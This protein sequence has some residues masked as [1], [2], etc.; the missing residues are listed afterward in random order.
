M[1]FELALI[2]VE[3]VGPVTARALV[4]SFGTAEAVFA[5]KAGE[6]ASIP[7]V[8]NKVA[9]SIRSKETFELAQREVEFISKNEISTIL[10]NSEDF[11]EKLRFCDDAPFLLFT[12]GNSS[13][14]KDRMVAVVGTRNAGEYGSSVCK[15]IIMELAA[16]KPVIVSGLALGIDTIAHRTALE[17]GLET[18]AALAHGLDRVYPSENKRLATQIRSQGAL[19]TE[20]FSNNQPDRENFPKR[21]RIVAGL[22]QATIVI[23]TAQKGGS[24]ITANLAFDY[25]RDVFAVPGRLTDKSFSGCNKLIA[26]NRAA[27][28]TSVADLVQQLGWEDK[29]KTTIQPSLFRQ[30]LPGEQL[31]VDYIQSKQNCELDMMSLDLRLPISRLNAELLQLELKGIVRAMPG[32]KFA[33][34]GL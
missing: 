7:G 1:L 6:L 4:N 32:K 13:L 31:L 3:G 5:A 24:M 14:I 25:S 20:I 15:E 16:Y 22:C 17:N 27:M 26:T 10:Y 23:E 8:T 30:L 29:K 28:F 12:K 33:L 2:L 34:T 21:N 18:I 9:K 11:P 19:V